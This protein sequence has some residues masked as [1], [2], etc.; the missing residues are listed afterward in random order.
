MRKITSMTM[1]VTLVVLIFNS[2]VLYVVPEGRVA[3]WAGWEFIGLSKGQWS[4]QHITV[5][6]LFVIAGLLHTWLNWTPIKNYMKNKA[7]EFRLFTTSFNIAVI[8]TAVVIVGT[9]YSVPPFSTVIQFGEHFKDEAAKTYGEP[10]YGHAELSSLDFYAKKEALDVEKAIVLLK[11]AGYTVTGKTD[12]LLEV[13]KASGVTP[14]KVHDVASKAKKAA[15]TVVATSSSAAVSDSG[16][17]ELQKGVLP[18]SPGSGLG[19]K[20]LGDIAKQYEVDVNKVI[21]GLKEQ[22][23]EAD[24]GQTLREIGSGAGLEPH[25]VYERMYNMTQP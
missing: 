18:M 23:I 2:V 22:N 15:A 3:Y 7:K 19:K 1:L 12:T 20:T 5:G 4:E 17:A 9:L 25:Q 6:L 11:E 21:A 16:S 8:L 14:K 10:P 24:A 13:A